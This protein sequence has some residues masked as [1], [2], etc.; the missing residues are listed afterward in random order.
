MITN[1]NRLAFRDIS[2][3]LKTISRNNRP[4]IDNSGDV[5]VVTPR[6][7]NCKEQRRLNRVL[8]LNKVNYYG[9]KNGLL[10]K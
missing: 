10:N 3:Y 1:V 9:N 5:W 6:L 2:K 8:G 4:I 7:L